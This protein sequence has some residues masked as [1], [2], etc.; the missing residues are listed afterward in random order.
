MLRRLTV[1]VHRCTLGLRAAAY[2]LRGWLLEWAYL[3][4]TPFRVIRP[5]AW[6]FTL[7]TGILEILMLLRLVRPRGFS[8]ELVGGGWEI[9]RLIRLIFRGIVATVVSF[10]WL[11]AWSPRY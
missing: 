5:R 3:L 11:L 1:L 9:V 10:F 4:A 8:T 7:F 2:T 6:L